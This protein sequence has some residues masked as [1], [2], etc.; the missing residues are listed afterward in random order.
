M[1]QCFPLAGAAGLGKARLQCFEFVI[2]GTRQ[3][4]VQGMYT[5]IPEL[6]FLANEEIAGERIPVLLQHQHVGTSGAMDAQFCLS[7]HIHAQHVVEE[8]D[9]QLGSAA[10]VPKVEGFT[11]EDAIFLRRYFVYAGT[12][13]LLGPE[14]H[15]RNKLH[16]VKLFPFIESQQLRR[17]VHISFM[18]NRQNVEIHSV[19]P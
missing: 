1:A 7:I 12:V 4:V 8:A 10:V 3:D 2:D 6:P 17:P 18:N 16:M 15:T 9:G 14:I 11:Q 5:Y 19:P 13:C